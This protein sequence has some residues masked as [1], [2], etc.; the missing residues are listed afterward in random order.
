MQK[1]EYRIIHVFTKLGFG[2]VTEIA[3]DSG[4]PD[5]QI[6]FSHGAGGSQKTMSWLANHL[7]TLGAEGW[8]LVAAFSVSAGGGGPITPWQ[9]YVLKRPK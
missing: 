9:Y 3:H 7:N 4:L 1:W 5:K 6:R 2:K 8:E